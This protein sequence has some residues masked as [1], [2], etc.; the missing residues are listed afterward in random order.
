MFNV[1]LLVLNISSHMWRTN[2]Q[3]R[4]LIIPD[5]VKE[6]TC[7]NTILKIEHP[8]QNQLAMGGEA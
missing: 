4:G 6:I 3:T 7:S 2:C 8:T 1:G 5:D